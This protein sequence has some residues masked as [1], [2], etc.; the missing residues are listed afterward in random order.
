MV[1]A[2]VHACARFFM[3]AANEFERTAVM[4]L[5]SDGPAFENEL[6][7][8]LLQLPQMP[9]LESQRIQLEW[10]LHHKR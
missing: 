6:E 3:Q 7:N 1:N 5:A 9:M 4:A 10:V 8:L 2:G